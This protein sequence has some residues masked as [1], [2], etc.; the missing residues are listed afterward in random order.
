MRILIVDDS[1]LMRAILKSFL[2]EAGYEVYEAANHEEAQFLFIT[3]K[4]EVI[5]KDLYTDD[6]EPLESIRYFKDLSPEVKI[7]IC[8]TDSS[9]NM[10]LESLKAGANDF[11]IKPLQKLNVLRMIN[12]LVE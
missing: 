11:L 8:S 3:S 4:P 6:W 10:I 9:R 1:P 12:K 2:D 5:I 7:I